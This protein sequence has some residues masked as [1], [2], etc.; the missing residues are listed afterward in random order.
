MVQRNRSSGVGA[1]TAGLAMSAALT[2]PAAAQEQAVQAQQS[3]ERRPAEM[4]V[5]P[6]DGDG[7]ATIFVTAQKRSENLQDVPIS[8]QAFDLQSL[9]D[10]G[11]QRLADVPALVPSMSFTTNGAGGSA[12][13][14]RGIG[15]ID[16]TAGQEAPVAIYVD[17]VY[18]PS[19]FGNNLGLRNVERVE[20][21]KGPQGT[22]FGRNATG[23]LVNVVTRRPSHEPAGEVSFSVGN[24]ETYEVSAYGTAGITENLAFDVTGYLRRQEEGY[25]V[26]LIT[27]NDANYRNESTIAS[28]IEYD[29]GSTVIT[30]SADYSLINAPQG[31]NREVYPGSISSGGSVFNGNFYDVQHTVDYHAETEVFGG[32]VQLEQEIGSLDLVSIT[33]YRVAEPFFYFDN[34]LNPAPFQAVGANYYDR[35][36]T[37]E[38][39]L[40]GR[41]GFL[42]WMV[43]AFYLQTT[44][45]LNLKI[46]AGP[47][48]ILAADFDSEVKTKS[49]SIFADAVFQLSPRDSITAG[50]RYTVDTR[51][52]TGAIGNVPTPLSGDETTWREPTWRVVYKRDFTEDIMAYVSYN[53][54]F[55]SGNYNLIPLTT[56]PYNP[57]I[58]DGYEIGAK[59]DLFD[60]RVRLN[61][62]G[63]YYDYQN[64]QVRTVQRLSTVVFNAASSE[65]KGFEA[66]LA[67]QPTRSLSLSASAAYVDGEYTSFPNAPFFFPVVPGELCPGV[68]AGTPPIGGNCQ[69]TIDASGTQL[70]RAPKF[71]ANFGGAFTIPTSVGEVTLT[72]RVSYRSSFPWDPAGRI[73]EDPNVL[74]NL[75][76]E[77]ESSD[78]RVS[79]RVDAENITGSHYAISGGTFPDADSFSAG[80]P[81][82]YR[83]TVTFRM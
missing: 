62:A 24:Y 46:F 69:T 36:F 32:Y 20:I 42:T 71:S 6:V 10:S 61:V 54:G 11:I 58:V 21:L 49:Y 41:S 50:L 67:I 27:G 72:G 63:F 22:L 4:T 38:I 48:R 47:S 28:K 3:S 66:E 56:A 55:K 43:G 7:V 33:G 68:T 60:R 80:T 39:R 31:N 15:A 81:T 18:R 40:S 70:I 57:E 8:V 59:F 79:I 44:A 9:E 30:A 51:R 78:E 77:W 17:G 82:L 74:V 23:G 45:G 83:A 2:S 14:I 26:N 52:V 19:L 65:I 12:I 34:D 76:A 53:R 29:G 25:G 37:E 73:R 16:V 5:Q 1:V 35:Q 64:M 13:F 75:G